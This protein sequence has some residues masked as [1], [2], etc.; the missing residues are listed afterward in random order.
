MCL[1]VLPLK[2]KNNPHIHL[3]LE[4]RKEERKRKESKK[5]KVILIYNHLY[6]GCAL[7]FAFKKKVFF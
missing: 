7:N 2:K 1:F 6:F 3:T 4:G 5:E